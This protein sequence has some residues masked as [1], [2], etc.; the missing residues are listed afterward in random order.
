MHL[1]ALCDP[2]LYGLLTG[3][4]DQSLVANKIA[5]MRTQRARRVDVRAHTNPLAS[6]PPSAKSRKPTTGGVLLRPT[7][8]K[9][10][11]FNG[12]LLCRR[13]HWTEAERKKGQA[14]GLKTVESFHT[15]GTPPVD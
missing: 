10:D 11:R 12:G 13:S 14:W 9:S 1:F 6:S 15:H 8:G 7:T 3:T 2:R 5:S 4:P